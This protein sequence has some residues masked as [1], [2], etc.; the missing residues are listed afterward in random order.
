MFIYN[1]ITIYILL[2][3]FLL[4][5]ADWPLSAAAANKRD[6][7]ERLKKRFKI[8]NFK[9]IRFK[10]L[11]FKKIKF[12]ILNFKITRFK[13]LNF[14]QKVTHKFYY[15]KCMWGT[16]WKFSVQNVELQF[17]ELQFFELQFFELQLF[18]LQLFELQYFELQ[19]YAVGVFNNNYLI[20][21]VMVSGE[22]MVREFMG[23]VKNSF[24]YHTFLIVC[25]L[26]LMVLSLIKLWKS[27]HCCVRKWWKCHFCVS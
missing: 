8:L 11:N 19:A 1:N 9:I 14:K 12:K 4:L 13:I 27:W 26:F 21:K 5:V 17:F 16:E 3:V 24:S 7:G 6:R 23:W 18:E 2:L 20:M 15:Y 10:I 22:Q 25:K